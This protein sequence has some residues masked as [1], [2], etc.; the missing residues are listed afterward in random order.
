MIEVCEGA[1]NLTTAATVTLR[2]NQRDKQEKGER[3]ISSFSKK[4]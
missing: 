2:S 3:R 1:R 4:E